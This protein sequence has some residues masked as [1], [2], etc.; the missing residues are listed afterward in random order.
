MFLRK[1]NAK[2]E[3][4][5][6]SAGPFFKPR[7]QLKLK[8]GESNDKYE[9]EADRVA[10]KVVNNSQGDAVQKKNGEEEVQQKPIASQVTPYYGH[11]TETT[12]SSVQKAPEEEPVQMMQEEEPIQ[13]A[14]EEEAVQ[15]KEEEE[16]VQMKEEEEPIQ[17]AEEEE[18]V[19]A[20][21]EEEPVQMKEEEE[22]V[23]AKAE[24]E[25]VQ[26]KAGTANPQPKSIES[27]LN[28]SKGGGQKL[29]GQA[30]NEMES[31][32]GADFS[33]VNIHTDDNA[34]QMSQDLGAKAFAHGNDVYF[35]KGQYDPQS[36]EGKHLLAHELTH[37]IQQKGMV[38]KQVQKN[39]N[40]TP[41][42]YNPPAT[43]T[44]TIIE[45]Q[46]IVGANPDGVYGTQTKAAVEDYQR[47]LASHGLYTDQIDGK[48]GNN[49]DIA[50]ITFAL[51][52]PK[53]RGYNCAGFAFKQ[54]I[55]IDLIPTRTIL[56]GMNRLPNSNAN[57]P[58]NHYKFW[59]WDIQVS[60]VNTRTGRRSGISDDFHIVGGQANNNGR[61]PDQVMSKNGQRPVEGPRPPLNWE[62]QSGQALDQDNNPI[63]NVNWVIHRS[64][65]KVFS[66]DRLP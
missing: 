62:I 27:R 50:H 29:G 3:D 32:F 30:K 7:V 51:T 23:Q 28:S 34:V 25:E 42:R 11:T 18:A 45:I 38:Q 41:W 66:S 15:M 37:T 56:S 36:S 57:V 55:W 35:N 44:R 13:K 43:V 26:K 31:G 53:R 8:V 54:F 20:K 52:A 63:P 40:S 10:D 61:G 2:N 21:E 6:P 9:Q 49:T 65:L 4:S 64:D 60:T 12:E 5:K 16:A 14:E 33:N 58:P 1:S 22:P 48:W 19:Q 47:V 24:E 59:F 46:G 39:P 17:K